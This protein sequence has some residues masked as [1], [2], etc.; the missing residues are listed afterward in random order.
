[1]IAKHQLY[2]LN[3]ESTKSIHVVNNGGSKE[4]KTR[5]TQII[6]ITLMPNI[7]KPDAISESSPKI[8]YLY[9]DFSLINYD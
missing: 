6:I 1:M 5:T 7:S 3:M 2:S 8:L 4:L 9:N